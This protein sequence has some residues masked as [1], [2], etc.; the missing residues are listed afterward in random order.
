MYGVNSSVRNETK[1]TYTK[2]QTRRKVRGS[3]SA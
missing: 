3:L 1:P 2:I